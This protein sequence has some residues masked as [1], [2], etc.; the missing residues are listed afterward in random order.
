MMISPHKTP[1][2]TKLVM[3]LLFA[4]AFVAIL[5]TTSVSAQ[6]LGNTIMSPFG[7]AGQ[8]STSESGSDGDTF[9]DPDSVDTGVDVFDEDEEYLISL[10]DDEESDAD[11]HESMEDEGNADNTLNDAKELVEEDSSK[12]T[13]EKYV[14]V[15]DNPIRGGEYPTFNFKLEASAGGMTVSSETGSNTPG[16]LCFARQFNTNTGCF[17][18]WIMANRNTNMDIVS[19]F[20][21]SSVSTDEMEEFQ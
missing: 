21:E 8:T 10:P 15:I 11:K 12:T 16:S 5:E 2:L 19:I 14:P 3:L 7:I 13:T 18:G 4:I 9:V 6:E 20:Y 17:A 1:A